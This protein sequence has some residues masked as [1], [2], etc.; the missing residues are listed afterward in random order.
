MQKK[1]Y[2]VSGVLHKPKTA[3]Q[4]RE[5][6]DEILKRFHLKFI[7]ALDKKLPDRF[8]QGKPD[9]VIL[10]KTDDAEDIITTIKKKSPTS[11]IIL[12]KEKR[13]ASWEKALEEIHATIAA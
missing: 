10:H 13:D 6:L 7:N 1:L 3:S 8:L 12:V 9:I 11:K 4:I 2:V 5:N